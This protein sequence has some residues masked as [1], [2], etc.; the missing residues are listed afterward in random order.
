MHELRAKFRGGI[1]IVAHREDPA[2]DATARFQHKHIG[3]IP[4][5][6]LRGRKSGGAGTDD[7]HIRHDCVRGSYSS[8]T[9]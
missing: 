3:P 9:R 5:Q 7:D 6:A 8:R 1:A 2:A 4:V